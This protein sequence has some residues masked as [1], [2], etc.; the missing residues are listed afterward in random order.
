M[1]RI[2]FLTITVFSLSFCG[3]TSS[4]GSLGFL[5][6]PYSADSILAELTETQGILPKEAEKNLDSIRK[7]IPSLPEKSV[8]QK[9]ILQIQNEKIQAEISV[10]WKTAEIDGKHLVLSAELKSLS[11]GDGTSCK[12]QD[13][14]RAETNSP[15][16]DFVSADITCGIQFRN[17]SHAAG[18]FLSISGADEVNKPLLPD[19]RLHIGNRTGLTVRD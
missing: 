3:P 5:N 19:G 18:Y 6:S 12:A 4:T 16:F 11:Y 15:F 13:F 9:K 14:R 2:C 17:S 7:M 10:I 1:K 8:Q